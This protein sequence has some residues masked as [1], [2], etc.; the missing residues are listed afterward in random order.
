MR[1]L[2]GFQKEVWRNC[3]SDGRL[4]ILN[5]LLSVQCVKLEDKKVRT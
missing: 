3:R 5:L 2:N 1:N 4:S